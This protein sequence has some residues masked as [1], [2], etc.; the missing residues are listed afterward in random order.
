MDGK[1]TNLVGYFKYAW[2][3][4]QYCRRNSCIAPFCKYH[5]SIIFRQ[6][7]DNLVFCK[8]VSNDDNQLQKKILENLEKQKMNKFTLT[9][10]FQVL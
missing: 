5:I 7:F 6:Y 4:T 10:V 8:T 1:M 9:P 3:H 2:F